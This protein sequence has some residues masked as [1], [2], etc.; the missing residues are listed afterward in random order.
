MNEAAKHAN[1]PT[2]LTE[3]PGLRKEL[4]SKRSDSGNSFFLMRACLL[5]VA[6]VTETTPLVLILFRLIL[7]GLRSLRIP[8]NRLRENNTVWLRRNGTLLKAAQKD[9]CTP[10]ARQS[11]FRRGKGSFRRLWM[12]SRTGASF[13]SKR[14]MR[15]THR[16]SNPT[17]TNLTEK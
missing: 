5:D 10:S 8:F 16:H 9:G 13:E 2:A 14:L 4:R 17:Q 11:S 3:G 7:T 12:P 15:M 1:P 6:G